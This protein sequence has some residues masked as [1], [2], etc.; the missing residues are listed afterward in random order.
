[1]RSANP[2]A[3]TIGH[4]LLT[5]IA[6]AQHRQLEREEAVSTPRSGRRETSRLFRSRSGDDEEGA[7]PSAICSAR[8]SAFRV[9]TIA[10]LLVA[11]FPL[12]SAAQ[13]RVVRFGRLWDGAKVIDN[14]VVTIKD[15]RIVTVGNGDD[16]LPAGSEII[17]LRKYSGLPGLIDLHTHITYYWDQKPGTR[18]RGQR[19]LPA[20][21]VYLA[22]ENARKTLETGVTTVRD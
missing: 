8:M 12:T 1:L 15:D 7:R 16:A 17:D 10:A 21:T 13:T 9:L 6:A 3:Q 2:F 4:V 14:A 19:R 11:L 5:T 22:Q 18:P 20:I